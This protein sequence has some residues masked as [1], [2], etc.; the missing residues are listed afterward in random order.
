MAEQDAH[1]NSG[2]E[3][4]I[5]NPKIGTASRKASV[6]EIDSQFETINRMKKLPVVE[7]AI[8]QGQVVY[9]KVK[10]EFYFRLSLY[11]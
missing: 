4:D 9:G 2:T 1:S 5:P 6:H 10:R 8:T 11:N 7:A 3:S